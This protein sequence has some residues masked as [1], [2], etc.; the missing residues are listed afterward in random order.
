LKKIAAEGR[1][2]QTRSGGFE[3]ETGAA[4]PQKWDDTEVIPPADFRKALPRRLREG[5]MAVPAV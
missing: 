4:P 5:G 1:Y 3:T 2:I